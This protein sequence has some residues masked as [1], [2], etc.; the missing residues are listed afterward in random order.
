MGTV[1]IK[2]LKNRLS[3][4]LHRTKK[5][6]EVVITE[7]GRPIALIQ[8]IGSVE[9]VTSRE[10]KLAKLAARGLITLPTRPPLKRVRLVKVSGVPISKAILEDRR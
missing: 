1:G 9:R 6:E 5:G 4:Y 8:P 2:E 10:A 7:R 3:Q